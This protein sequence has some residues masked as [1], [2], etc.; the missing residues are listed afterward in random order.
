[1]KSARQNLTIAFN[2]AKSGTYSLSE[3]ANK[4][5]TMKREPLPVLVL[6]AWMLV[7]APM[8]E[9]SKASDL[10]QGET[11]RRLKMINIFWVSI[12]TVIAFFVVFSLTGSVLFALLAAA[13]QAPLLLDVTGTFDGL[14]TELAAAC[15]ILASCY[16]MA[17]L[18]Q[19]MSGWLALAAGIAAGAAVLT[20]TIILYTL[21]IVALVL[22]ILIYVKQRSTAKSLFAGIVFLL[23]ALVVT[24][25]WLMRNAVVLDEPRISTRA[26]LVLYE[27]MLLDSMTRE[28]YW[29]SFYAWA[30][31]SVK[32]LFEAAF[33]FK[34]SDLEA[35]GTLQRLNR[36]H[37]PEDDIAKDEG[38]PELSSN[39]H[40]KVYSERKRQSINFARQGSGNSAILIEDAMERDAKN[41]ILNH[42]LDHIALMV[43][44]AW[45]GMWI[46]GLT[47]GWSFILILSLFALPALGLLTRRWELIAFVVLP[48]AVFA[49]LTGTTHHLPRFTIPL[50]P[51]MIVSAVVLSQ[52]ILSYLSTWRIV[53]RVTASF[54]LLL[55]KIGQSSRLMQNPPSQLPQPSGLRQE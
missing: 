53:S 36:I 24:G 3:T 2:V 15:L 16:M 10:N 20:K 4:M 7:S 28:E 44:L 48:I 42:P 55:L 30:P 26:G 23:G 51:A 1:M 43:P 49:I 27:R 8:D 9:A 6:A 18:V 45:R 32:R 25:P 22:A 19:R 54:R 52:P 17:L 46:P 29:G 50:V 31:S 13:V 21:P 39:Y 5:P 47:A 11:I 33:G 37:R 38:R 40:S 41:W 34:R 14:K 12:I 35:G